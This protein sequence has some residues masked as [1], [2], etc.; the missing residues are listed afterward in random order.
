MKDKRGPRKI[1]SFCSVITEQ[2]R[3]P[4]LSKV[5]ASGGLTGGRIFASVFGQVISYFSISLS[6]AEAEWETPP[7]FCTKRTPSTM[8]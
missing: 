8:N 4:L 3:T 2:K 1:S 7:H 6:E 5:E